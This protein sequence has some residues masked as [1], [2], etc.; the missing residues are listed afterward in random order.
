MFVL[1]IYVTYYFL[2]SVQ[3][4]YN[5]RILVRN[6]ESNW[7]TSTIVCKIL[8]WTFININIIHFAILTKSD[9]LNIF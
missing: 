9:N 6:K 1:P 4:P 5:N 8:I 3:R 7:I 2:I